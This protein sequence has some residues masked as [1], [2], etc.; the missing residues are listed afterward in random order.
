[1]CIRDRAYIAA[2]GVGV[3]KDESVF[4]EQWL[5]NAV[6][7]EPIPENVEKYNRVY[8]VYKNTYEALKGT[9]VKLQEM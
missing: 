1:M 9:Y 3:F 2:M 7:T 8:E 6:K 4:Y 5:K